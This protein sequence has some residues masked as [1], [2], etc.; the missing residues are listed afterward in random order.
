MNATLYKQGSIWIESVLPCFL[1]HCGQLQNRVHAVCSPKYASG[2]AMTTHIGKFEIVR[3][4]G[5]GA[6]GEVLLGRDPVLQREVAIKT[7][8]TG[9]KFDE[10]AKAKFEFEARSTALLSHPNIVTV[11]DFGQQGGMAYLVMEHI[12]G[13]SVETLIANGSPKQEL[14]EILIQV[15]DGLSYAHEE[16]LVHRDVKPSN[17]LV[18]QRGKKN[19]AKIV[20]FGVAY[21]ERVNEAAENEWMGTAHYMA[22]EYLRTGKA[23]AS[24][25]LFA[26]G[27][28][29]YEILSGGVKPFEGEDMTDVLSAVLNQ[30]PPP[31]SAKDIGGLPMALISVVSK[32]LD[33]D[34]LNRYQDA[35]SLG[36]AISNALKTAVAAS[37]AAAR[38]ELLNVVVGKGGQTTCLSLRVALRQAASGAQIRVKPGVYKESIVLDKDVTIAGEGDPSQVVIE[39]TGPPA[40]RVKSGRTI[41]K[42]LTLRSTEEQI[43][44]LVDVIEGHITL[45]ECVLSAH[46]NC[47]ANVEFGAEITLHDCVTTG[48]GRELVSVLGKANLHGGHLSGAT[49]AAISIQKNGHGV[50][51]NVH[52]GPGDGVGILLEDQA[53]ANIE[54]VAIIG[55]DEGSIELDSSSA[56][57]AKDS[58]FLNSKYA[59]LI[60]KGRS[61]SKIEDC[62]FNEHE[63]SGIHLTRETEAE[64]KGCKFH[65]NA[66]YGISAIDGGKITLDSCEIAR[67]QLAGALIHHRGKAN[68]NQS[69]ILDG[70]TEG[71]HC[72]YSAEASLEECEI[73]ENAKQGIRVDS[74]GYVAMRNCTVHYNRG[75]GMLMESGADVFLESCTIKRNAL[76]SISW[77]KDGTPPTLLGN[78]QVEAFS[79]G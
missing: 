4:I 24:A 7:I 48:H 45:K 21:T 49:K 27:V 65:D 16:G 28:I 1:Q 41:L 78:N 40:V 61:K 76:G 19:I 69:K 35:E 8:Q 11:F 20:D 47:A 75:E 42:G 31:L 32:A 67:S 58:Q 63:S 53:R 9:Q 29:L 33:K 25:D 3:S 46:G 77:P 79:A 51:Q 12:E 14:L 38:P 59:G 55:F 66:G 73:K 60:Q 18:S 34:P 36:Q 23:T 15:C 62:L 13:D 39:T 54:G 72:F 71:L 26:V 68:I 50:L 5:K 10:E 22:P 74:N 17:I 37:T 64:L 56:L 30:A 43:D 6:M 70:S 2:L 52:M 57:Y 44:S